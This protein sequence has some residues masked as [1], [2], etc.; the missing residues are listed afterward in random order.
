MAKYNYSEDLDILYIYNNSNGKKVE[1]NIVLDNIVI[2]IGNKGEVLGMEIDS[3]S[4]FLNL[5]SEKLSNLMD[6]RI[7][8][9]KSSH[10]IALGLILIAEQR[11]HY[12]QF[13]LPQKNKAPICFY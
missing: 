3:A 10:M 8:L 2:D 9:I 12:F 7:D 5:S 4:K 11:E 6:A 13:A 1:G